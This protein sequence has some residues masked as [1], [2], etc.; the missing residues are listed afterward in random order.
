MTLNYSV[1]YLQYDPAVCSVRTEPQVPAMG[2]VA[3]SAIVLT[4]SGVLARYP[5]TLASPRADSLKRTRLLKSAPIIL[6]AQG[7]DN[8]KRRTPSKEIPRDSV[9][10]CTSNLQSVSSISASASLSP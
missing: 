5:W 10:L 8:Y 6:K 4:L 3:P 7:S 1:L 2:S 9:Y